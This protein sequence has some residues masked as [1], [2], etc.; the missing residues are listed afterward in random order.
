MRVDERTNH[1]QV[2]G[3]T[4]FGAYATHAT[5]PLTFLYPI[6]SGYVFAQCQNKSNAR[7]TTQ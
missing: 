6:P 1:S 5:V 2:M 3:V 7:T 4:R